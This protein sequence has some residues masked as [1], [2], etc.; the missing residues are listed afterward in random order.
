MN[1]INLPP[2]ITERVEKAAAQRGLTADAYAAFLM[3]ASLGADQAEFEDSC[4]AIAEGI[5]DM[6][7]GRMISLEDFIAERRAERT[8]L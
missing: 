7:A 1:R 2:E 8:A 5:A 6:E 4:Q 3:Q